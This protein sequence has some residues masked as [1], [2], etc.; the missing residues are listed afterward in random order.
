MGIEEKGKG[1]LLLCKGRY[2][3]GVQLTYKDAERLGLLGPHVSLTVDQFS[4]VR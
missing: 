4:N 1:E 2:S 3:K